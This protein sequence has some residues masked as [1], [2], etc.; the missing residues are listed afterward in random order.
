MRHVLARK[1]GTDKIRKR[2][3]QK[4]KNK[5]QKREREVR[6]NLGGR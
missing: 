1:L 2:I 6:G 4:G 5:R 3:S